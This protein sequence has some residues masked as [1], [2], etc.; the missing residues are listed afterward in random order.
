MSGTRSD[1]LPDLDLL[2]GDVR[3]LT[4][5]YKAGDRESF[6]CFRDLVSLF[7][8]NTVAAS[9]EFSRLVSVAER[10][11][12]KKILGGAATRPIRLRNGHYL[13][14]YAYLSRESTN[15]GPRLKVRESSYQYQ[16][17]KDGEH[18]MFRYDY[19]RLPP[20]LHPAAHLHVRSN[21]VVSEVL[22]S[23]PHE[24]VHYPTGSV[25]IEGVLR[26]LIEQCG[27]PT[28]RDPSIWRPLLHEAEIAFYEIAHQPSS[29]PRA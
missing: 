24:R 18:W 3:R 21:L 15:A 9:G 14:I 12:D 27:I 1:S 5:G 7:L 28:A 26:L 13:R 2:L 19:S 8:S 29:G 6:V 17:D 10:D 4:D 16:L 25:S 11:A 20:E 23:A 22:G